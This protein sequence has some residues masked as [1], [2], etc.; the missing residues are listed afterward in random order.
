LLSL[1]KR[2]AKKSRPAADIKDG[3]SLGNE[4]DGDLSGFGQLRIE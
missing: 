1:H 2:A 4:V 3:R